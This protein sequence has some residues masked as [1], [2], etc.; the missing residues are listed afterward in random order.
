MDAELLLPF[1]FPPTL[2]C[3]LQLK[4]TIVTNTGNI[5]CEAHTKSQVQ[6]LIKS[7]THYSFVEE[8]DV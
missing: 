2:P 4:D 1:T 8:G 6:F 5:S 7:F 3:I